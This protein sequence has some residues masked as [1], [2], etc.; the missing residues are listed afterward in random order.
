M[1]NERIVCVP[2]AWLMVGMGVNSKSEMMGRK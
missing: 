1:L 2:V